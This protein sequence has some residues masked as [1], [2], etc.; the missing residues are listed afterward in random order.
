MKT[1][2]LLLP[3]MMVS[4]FPQD[5]AKQAIAE[6]TSPKSP[7]DLW[8]FDVDKIKIGRKARYDV[9]FYVALLDSA[10]LLKMKDTELIIVR[11]NS[12]GNSQ[13]VTPSNSV[14]CKRRFLT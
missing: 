10:K 4:Y 5:N 14:F 13:E 11:D 1:I 9:D 8:S 6:L 12:M 2:M 3:C 7:L